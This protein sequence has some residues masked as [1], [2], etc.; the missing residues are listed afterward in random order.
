MDACEGERKAQ[1]KKEVE[2]KR[3]EEGGDQEPS[4]DGSWWCII[5]VS[6]HSSL[7][8][9]SLESKVPLANVTG[10]KVLCVNQPEFRAGA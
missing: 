8:P 3:E 7:S 6:L 5:C 9:K 10:E 4:R 2:R 1:G